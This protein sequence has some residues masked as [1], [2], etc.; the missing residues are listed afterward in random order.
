MTRIIADAP[1][2]K[3]RCNGPQ[4]HMPPERALSPAVNVRSR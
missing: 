3:P 4:W 2:L 1:L